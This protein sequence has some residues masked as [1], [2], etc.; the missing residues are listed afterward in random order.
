MTFFKQTFPGI[1]PSSIFTIKPFFGFVFPHYTQIPTEEKFLV[2]IFLAAASLGSSS[3]CLQYFKNN[4][5]TPFENIHSIPWCI[6][7]I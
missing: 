7:E 4:F 5:L 1:L 3:E 6:R 2:K